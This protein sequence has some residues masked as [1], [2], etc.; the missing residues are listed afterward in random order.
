VYFPRQ[1]ITYFPIGGPYTST[2][3]ALL[4]LSKTSPDGGFQAPIVVTGGPVGVA[5]GQFL[6]SNTHIVVT[7]TGIYYATY[8]YNP[9]T[10]GG[11]FKCPLI[12]ACA[13]TQLATQYAIY[14]LAVDGAGF[15]FN[16]QQAPQN[17]ISCP[18]GGCPITPPTPLATSTNASRIL[19]DAA[20]VYW[21]NQSNTS[22]IKVDKATSTIATLAAAQS[23][24]YA[25]AVDDKTVFWAS[26]NNPGTI[27][28]CAIAGCGGVPTPLV[29]N[30]TSVR[31]LAVDAKAIYWMTQTS[32]GSIFKV[33]K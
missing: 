20:N 25:M 1:P 15:V 13:P 18:L 3:G 11:V 2:D 17:V 12:G 21:V 6:D 14:A 27:S 16:S 22:I 30:L 28:S 19:T 24:A 4:K 7:A 32:G 31:G 10:G 29:P 26:Q 8:G 23:G 5:G 9:T 33:V